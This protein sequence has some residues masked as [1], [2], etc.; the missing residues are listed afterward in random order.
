MCHEKPE[1]ISIPC[2]A[3]EGFGRRWWFLRKCRIC[4]GLGS[5]SYVQKPGGQYEFWDK[6]ALTQEGKKAIE[7]YHNGDGMPTWHQLTQL[8][9]IDALRTLTNGRAPN[10]PTTKEG[11][12]IHTLH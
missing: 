7:M 8:L 10:I 12:T 11:E 5:V 4:K 2:A 9:T 6:W 1:P 3:C